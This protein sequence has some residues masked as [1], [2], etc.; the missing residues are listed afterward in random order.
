MK[1]S[2]KF[3]NESESTLFKD[4]RMKYPKFVLI[5]EIDI[6]KEKVAVLRNV[7][8][9]IWEKVEESSTDK[10]LEFIK[11]KLHTD[12]MNHEPQ[13][14]DRDMEDYIWDILFNNKT[15]GE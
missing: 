1:I 2:E 15:K 9:A 10:Q 12:F 6:E 5:S 14:F 3:I 4:E 13:T 7:I 8:S 11:R